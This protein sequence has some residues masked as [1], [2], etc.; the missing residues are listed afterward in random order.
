MEPAAIAVLGEALGLKHLPAATHVGEAAAAVAGGAASA[1][2]LVWPEGLAGA[3]RRAAEGS[4]AAATAVACVRQARAALV[5]PPSRLHTL[6]SHPRALAP[7]C[8]HA[9]THPRTHALTRS[10]PRARPRA[11]SP[12]LASR[13]FSLRLSP[14]RLYEPHASGLPPAPRRRLAPRGSPS[15]APLHRSPAGRESAREIP[16]RY[17]RYTARRG[18]SRRSTV[19][20]TRP[21]S[22]RGRTRMAAARPMVAAARPPP[23]RPPQ[24]APPPPPLSPPP[25]PPPSPPPPPPPSRP[26]APPDAPAR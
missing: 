10:R 7:S 15:A 24:P 9:L 3:A 8:P 25:P 14:P 13:L 20:R 26:A 23:H 16:E 5:S 22:A 19:S 17:P 1:E 4:I 2:G 6:A 21:R 11:A 18:S 12:F